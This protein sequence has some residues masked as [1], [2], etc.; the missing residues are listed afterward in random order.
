MGKI[1]PLVRSEI[2]KIADLHARVFGRRKGVSQPDLH[3]RFDEILFNNPWYDDGL[4]SLVYEDSAGGIVG[5]LGVVPRTMSYGGAP[6]KV[7]VSTQFMVEPD[8]RSSLAALQLLKSFLMGSQDLSI[9]DGATDSVR[10]LWEGLGGQSSHLHNIHWT[11]PLRPVRYVRHLLH[12]RSASRPLAWLL[13]PFCG[14]LDALATRMRKSPFYEKAPTDSGE[15]LRVDTIVESLPRF[16]KDTSLRPHYDQRSLAW[17]LDQAAEKGSPAPLR[18]VG[19]LRGKAELLGWYLYYVNPGKVSQVVQ[20]VATQRSIDD[21]LAHLFYDAWSRGVVAVSGRLEPRFTRNLW[22]NRCLF[23]C[24][25][26]LTLVHS[27]DPELARAILTGDAFLTRL[28]AEWW[29]RF[30]DG[31][32]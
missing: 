14:A 23:H 9:V 21:V 24:C 8:K 19:V 10:K 4:P 11:H 12:G 32:D 29:M 27:R 1:R 28:E 20:I 15:D 30:S 5:F 7:A 16:L 3:S 2:P 26:P 25:G 22:D 6:V 17:L 13:T 31:L 18:K